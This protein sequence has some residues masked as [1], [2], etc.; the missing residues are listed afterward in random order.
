M[1][2]DEEIPIIIH[3]VQE[4][5]MLNI[6][7]AV[8]DKFPETE[9]ADEILKDFLK[10]TFKHFK[11]NELLD[12]LDSIQAKVAYALKH[13]SMVRLAYWNYDGP[14]SNTASEIVKEI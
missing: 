4:E 6:I 1:Y 8:L 5:L 2:I 7:I 13:R 12:D 14:S 3:D 11:S 10:Q 9:V